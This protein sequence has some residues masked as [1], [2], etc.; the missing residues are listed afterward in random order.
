MSKKNNKMIFENRE[1]GSLIKW[2]KFKEIIVPS[3][4]E[5]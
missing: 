4:I 5:E 2:N 3:I 1:Q